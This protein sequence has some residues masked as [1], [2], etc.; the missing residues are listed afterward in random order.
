M[1]PTHLG[2]SSSLLQPFV[3]SS[4]RAEGQGF[5]DV[6]R[7]GEGSS[8]NTALAASGVSACLSVS[9]RGAATPRNTFNADGDLQPLFGSTV[10]FDH[11]PTPTAQLPIFGIAAA[12]LNPSTVENVPERTIG[13]SG[14][15][16]GNSAGASVGRSNEQAKQPGDT[17]LDESERHLR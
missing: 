7:M 13:D 6:P 10:Q 9:L 14:E 16:A 1:F 17:S 15:Q 8:G 3:S 2:V 11:V 4:Y 5:A 12:A